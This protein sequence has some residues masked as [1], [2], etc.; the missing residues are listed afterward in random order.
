MKCPKCGNEVLSTDVNCKSCGAHLATAFAQQKASAP[1]DVKVCPK[2]GRQVGLNDNVC[3]QCTHVF[4]F[5]A[6]NPTY[7]TISSKNNFY[8]FFTHIPIIL[9]ILTLIL[10]IILLMDDADEGVAI[11]GGIAIAAIVFFLA[12]VIIS[13]T[14]VIVDNLD[15]IAMQTHKS[16]HK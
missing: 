7:T 16:N 4:D 11:F 9:A 14:I 15:F 2:C 13:P 8:K 10:S 3:P 6:A 1:K 5:T 12:S